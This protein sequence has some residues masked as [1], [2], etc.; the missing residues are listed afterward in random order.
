MFGGN[1]GRSACNY[2]FR[3]G[4]LVA[5]AVL[6]L[7]CNAIS[8]AD[9]LSIADDDGDSQGSGTT[10]TAGSTTADGS[11]GTGDSG[12]GAGVTIGSG[13]GTSGSGGNTSSGN[14]SS[15]GAGAGDPQPCQYPAGPYGVALGQTVPPTISWQGYAPGQ[16]QAT[17]ISIQD[18]F[19]CDGR[20]GI[21]AIMIDTSQYG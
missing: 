11:S 19:D 17:N 3:F 8:G 20:F 1:M 9:G 15:S 6:G 12:A 21:H 18:L 4:S 10:A 2:V 5:F 14:T 16:S 13:P 7:A